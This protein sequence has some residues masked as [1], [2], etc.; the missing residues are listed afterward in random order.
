M[1]DLNANMITNQ[2]IKILSTMYAIKK[3]KKSFGILIEMNK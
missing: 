1:F 2:N 3:I